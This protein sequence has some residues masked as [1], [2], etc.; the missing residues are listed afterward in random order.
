M[1]DTEQNPTNVPPEEQAFSL[2]PPPSPPPASKKAV[3]AKL[4]RF[5]EMDV[6][7]IRIDPRTE[8]CLRESGIDHLYAPASGALT[9]KALMEL[10]IQEPIQVVLRNRDWWCVTGEPLLAEAKRLLKPPRLLP[11]VVREDA[12]KD[13]LRTIVVVEQM[14][15][16]TRNQMHNTALKARVSVLLN[17]ADTM[18]AL[19]AQDLTDEE[20]ADILRRSLR[21]FAEAK[22]AGK[23]KKGGSNGN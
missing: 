7:T 12:G 18:P 23:Q 17:C 9:E 4:P 11:V 6:D 2:T 15:R 13:G 3:R 5:V 1:G 14:I 20:W 10:A 8:K 19:F 21:R 16:P 22:K